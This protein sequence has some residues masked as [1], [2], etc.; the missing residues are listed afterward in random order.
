M[1]VAAVLV[2]VQMMQVQVQV[3]RMVRLAMATLLSLPLLPPALILA[4]TLLLQLQLKMA[5]L[6]LFV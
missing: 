2:S 4:P 5:P 6:P 1:A 3:P